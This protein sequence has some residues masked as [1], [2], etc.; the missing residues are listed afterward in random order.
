MDLSQLFSNSNSLMSKKLLSNC[1]INHPGEKGEDT[2]QRWLEWFREYLPKRYSVDKAIIIDSDGNESDQID[3]VIYDRVFSP[4]LI[5]DISSK[6][7]TAESVY[8]VFEVKQTINKK[9]IEYS[10]EK[11][12]SVRRLNRTYTSFRES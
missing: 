9:N 11:A 6:Y 3:V 12:E 7:I 10:M 1:V 2:N 4:P 8:A 5:E